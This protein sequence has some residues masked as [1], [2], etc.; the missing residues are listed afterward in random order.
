MVDT[1][2]KFGNWV[3]TQKMLL[4]IVA[5]VV[6]FPVAWYLLLPNIGNIGSVVIYFV[7]LIIVSLLI[8]NWGKRRL[9]EES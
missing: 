9:E 1:W 6:F 8:R 4:L 5:I 3:H 7:Y 2:E